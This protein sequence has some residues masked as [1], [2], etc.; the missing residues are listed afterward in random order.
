MAPFLFRQSMQSVTGL[1]QSIPVGYSEASQRCM[2]PSHEFH[3]RSAG[4]SNEA[5]CC[6]FSLMS[7]VL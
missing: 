6:I 1:S 7:G 2:P 4:W 3:E 5:I